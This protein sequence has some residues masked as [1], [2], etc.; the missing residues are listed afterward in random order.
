MCAS[1][2]VIVANDAA[3]IIIIIIISGSSSSS[4]SSRVRTL[5]PTS[6]AYQGID[7]L[8][9]TLILAFNSGVSPSSILG[10]GKGR[11]AV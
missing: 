8:A 2:I 3:I 6:V 11:D 1:T 7:E 4:S 10:G 5:T 9:H